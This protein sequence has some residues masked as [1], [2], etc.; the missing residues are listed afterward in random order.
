MAERFAGIFRDADLPVQMATTLAAKPTK[1]AIHIVQS[2]LHYGFSSD[3]AEILFVCER[4][5]SGSKTSP[6]DARM[7][8]KRKQA[9]DP[10]ELKNRRFCC[11]RTTWNRSIC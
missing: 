1:G 6:K 2:S 5:L 8:S 4:D 7:P 3:Q 10:L 11:S 9:I